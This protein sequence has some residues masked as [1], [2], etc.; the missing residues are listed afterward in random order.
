MSDHNSSDKAKHQGGCAQRVSGSPNAPSYDA[1]A[2]PTNLG[3]CGS[4]T[5]PIAFPRDTFVF[6][7][8]GTLLDTLPD[9]VELT[10]ATLRECGFP[11]HTKEEIQ[12]YVGS[13]VKALIRLAVPASAGEDAVERAADLWKEL[14]PQYGYRLTQPYPGIEDALRELKESG[15]K[16]AVLSNKYDG[17]TR[18]V[19]ARFFPGVFDSVHGESPDFPRKPDPTGLRKVLS[20]LG[21]CASRCAF[22]GDSSN[23]MGVARAVDALAV[24]VSWGYNPVSTLFETGADLVIHDPCELV[25]L[26]GA[27]SQ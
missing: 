4:E 1:P 20:E 15:V 2:A 3:N 7:L 9:L 13:G 21:S 6:D 18:E 12:S 11:Q 26:L 25:D 16:L 24:G 19:I 10:N 27:Q 8:D 5:S 23:D 22:V 14:Y 17:A